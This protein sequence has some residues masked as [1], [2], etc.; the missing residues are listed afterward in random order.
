MFLFP[1]VAV[2][3][4]ERDHAFIRRNVKDRCHGFSLPILMDQYLLQN[5]WGD[6]ANE[7]LLFKSFNTFDLRL[8]RRGARALRAGPKVRLNTLVG[9]DSRFL[10][11][12]K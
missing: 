10:A 1:T 9:R 7:I 12:T 4:F 3:A 5:Y 8:Y 6:K 2:F 11:F